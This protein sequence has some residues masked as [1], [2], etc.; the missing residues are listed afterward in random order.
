MTQPP[1]AEAVAEADLAVIGMTC[2]SCVARVE[3]KL[4]RLPGVTATV[5]LALERAHVTVDPD[6]D[7]DPQTLVDTV[8]AAGYDATVLLATPKTDTEAEAPPQTAA[9]TTGQTSE[10]TTEA[11]GGA[12][13]PDPSEDGFTASPPTPDLRGASTARRAVIAAVLTVPVVAISMVPALQFRGWQWL[14]AL[15]S[16]PVVTWGAWPFHRAAARAARHGA[17]TMDTLVSLGVIA[18][19]V[20]SWWA[21]LFGGA[22]QLGMTMHPSL[23]PAASAGHAGTPELYFEV[24]A[25][26]TTFLLIGRY[27]EERARRRAGDALRALLDL[28]AKD[29]T[30]LGPDGAG[31]RVPVDSLT[32]GTRFLVRP[33]EKVAT[34]GLVLDGTSAVDASLLTGEPVPVE[35]GPGDTV[36]GATVNTTGALV[37]EAT[38]VGAATRLAQIGRLVA[39]AQ[40]G[41][42]AV[43]RL[44]DRVS[45]VFVPVV[46]ALSLVTLVVWLVAGGGVSAAFTAAVAVLI[47]ACPC[48]LGLATPTALLVGTG[49]G[50]QLG[51]LI[52]GPQVLERT[53]SVDT[54]V[55]DKTGTV[56]AGQMAVVDV[57]EVDGE[58]P[59]RVL[60][61]AAAVEAFSEHPVARAVVEAATPVV[62]GTETEWNVHD[63]RSVPGGGVAGVVRA[64]HVGVGMS[65]RVLVGQASWLAGEGVRTD[66]ASALV[67]QVEREAATAV[68]VAWGG[69]A[70]GVVALRDPVRE[71]A[72]QAVAELTALGLRTVLLTGDNERTAQAVAAQVGVDEVLAQ[73]SPEDKLAEISRL[74]ASGRSVAMVGDGVN[75][76]AALAQAD[77]G[78]AVGTGA[79]V[80]AQAADVVLVRADPMLVPQAV[81]LSQATLRIIKQNLAWAFGYNVAALPLAAAGLLNPMI[82]GA[83]MALSSVLVVTNSLR[84]RRFS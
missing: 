36:T 23:W 61:M 39:Q 24:G 15:L 22:G 3:K 71:S 42:A 6:A 8:R 59:E 69:S 41:K 31:R 72:P 16:L 82:A 50:A 47:I 83:A 9:A 40:T 20:W 77:L 12:T 46:V 34:D 29:V 63:F 79:D 17:S 57:L 44:A 45:A 13:D 75:D 27:A 55:L 80:A 33:G 54:V 1:T 58:D 52:K 30:V 37:V 21:L 68:V 62:G 4:G 56:T 10:R 11:P 51:I 19:T 53:R 74:Q 14:V 35:V 73:V 49:R 60:E 28:G 18:A 78:L 76:A 81:R 32:V 25:V 7:V 65:Q 64:P 5:N 70:R 84:L 26:V 66:A 43:Q 38:A 2:A 48:A 67:E